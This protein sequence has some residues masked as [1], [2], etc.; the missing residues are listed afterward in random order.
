MGV[1]E[2][3]FHEITEADIKKINTESNDANT[4]GGARDL[5]FGIEHSPCLDRL[6]SQETVEERGIVY[7]VVSFDY[8]DR[9]GVRKTVEDV[10][11]AFRP[12]NSRPSEVRIAQINKLPFFKDIPPDRGE[13]DIL[14]MAFIRM[15]HGNP[16][17]Q[18]LTQRQIENPASNPIIASALREALRT[19]RKNCAV[20]FSVEIG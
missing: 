10:K 2:V 11:Y 5:R 4:G 8:I 15:S 7:R 9:D 12:T 13:D 20:I 17:A 16:Q 6:F 14:F 3:L 18:Y 19:R 1:I